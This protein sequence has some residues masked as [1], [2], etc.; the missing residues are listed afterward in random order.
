MNSSK[1]KNLNK[2]HF[3][4]LATS[5]IVSTLLIACA[6][7]QKNNSIS[8]TPTIENQ[9]DIT[10]VSLDINLIG[11]AVLGAQSAEGAAE[12]VQYHQAS[13]RVYAIN[14]SGHEA[15]IEILNLSDISAGAL[16]KNDQGVINNSNL[17]VEK[18]LNLNLHTPGDANSI[19][20]SDKLDLLAVALAAKDVNTKGNIAFYNIAG[21]TPVFIKNIEVGYLPDMVTF[22]P[23]SNKVIVANEG[24][25]SG[26]YSFDPE[27]TISIIDINN[28]VIADTATELNFNAF[29]NKQAELEAQ[30]VVFANP[31]GRTIKGNVIKT[32]VSMDL[33]P[34]YVAVT[35]DSSTAYISLQENNAI[36]VVDLTNNTLVEI[37]GLGFKDWSKYKMD[38]SDKDQGINF[39]QYDNLYGMYQPD[40]L[41]TYN[42]NGHQYIVSA[43]EGDGREYF[44]DS[45]NES[46]CLADG[47]LAYDKEDGCLSYIDESRVKNLTLD[48][49]SFANVNND[50]NDIGRLIVSTVKGDTNNDG[51]YEQ[52][53]T[54]GA[55]SFSIWDSQGDVVFDSGDDI[56]LITAKIHGEAFNNNE[57]ENKGDTRSDAKGAE[58]EA[59]AL[60]TIDGR[61]YAFIGL[62]RMGGIMVYDIT[63]PLNA[64]YIDYFYNRGTIEGEGITGDLAPEGMAFIE[65]TANTPARLIVG[66][67]ISGSVSIWEIVTKNIE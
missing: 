21:A 52:L 54:Y 63:D 22:S 62:E 29:N 31:S 12:I 4:P 65:A 30:G 32:T 39:Q 41:A 50:D 38:A 60:G 59:L 36:A 7:D 53:Y 1:F 16:T 9:T 15:T 64:T 45:P 44:F 3:K 51:K 48:A 43:N 25:P 18:T 37:L 46:A 34:E 6:A 17:I 67:E 47:G 58:P 20:I 14:S 56:G 23:D 11:R 26:D 35:E 24:E 55:R 8:Y 57:D 28:A 40:T 10:P 33:E 66:N 49:T 5:L 61:T 27:G 19:A 42:V 13:N 2:T